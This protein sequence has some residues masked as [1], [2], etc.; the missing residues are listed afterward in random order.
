MKP[1]VKAGSELIWLWIIIKSKNREIL[2]SP[3][4]KE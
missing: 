1:A 3:I 4:T 2:S